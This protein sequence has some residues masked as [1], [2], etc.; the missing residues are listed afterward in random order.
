MAAAF[1][2]FSPK[3]EN[4]RLFAS[5]QTAIKTDPLDLYTINSNTL[6]AVSMSSALSPY[7]LGELT[8]DNSDESRKEIIEYTVEQGDSIKSI[9]QKFNISANT[10]IWANDL[11]SSSS[12]KLGQTLII[13]PVSGVLHHVKKGDTL[14]DIAAKY[15]GK[16]SDILAINEISGDQD[17]YVGDILIVP[18]GVIPP[19]SVPQQPTFAPLANS[20]FICPIS[21]CRRTQGLHWYNAVDFSDGKCGAPIFAAAAGQVLNIKYGYNLG[22]GNTISIM[23]PNGTITSYGHIL[24]AAVNQGNNV[25]QGQIIAYMGGTPG[26][27]G[28]GRSTGCH[29]HFAVKGANNPFTR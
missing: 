28:A 16:V 21:S 9:A 19:K 6:A 8:A 17:V 23:H 22:A 14:D 3:S 12:V 13:L 7:I 26:T 20:Y 25:S 27:P 11:S 1:A 10:I 5:Q 15:K 24:S 29:V 2:S 18:N 4:D